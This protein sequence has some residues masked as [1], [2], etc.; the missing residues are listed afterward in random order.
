MSEIYPQNNDLPPMNDDDAEG[1]VCFVPEYIEY[2]GRQ[3]GMYVMNLF[4]NKPDCLNVV[5]NSIA[6]IG[7]PNDI[8]LIF[9]GDTTDPDCVVEW[10]V[11]SK[12]GKAI[13]N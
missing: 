8:N 5:F 2:P 11:D 3:I 7:M 1:T 4:G 9:D 6:A 12:T 10:L 13:Q